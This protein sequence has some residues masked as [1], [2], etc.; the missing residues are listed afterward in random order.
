MLFFGKKEK[1]SECKQC[2][3]KYRGIPDSFPY[4]GGCLERMRDREDNSK[5]ASKMTKALKKRGDWFRKSEG[6]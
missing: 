3:S 6:L 4:C 1:V 5:K 2:D